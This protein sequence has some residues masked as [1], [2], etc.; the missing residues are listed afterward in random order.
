MIN[1]EKNTLKNYF[2]N[3]PDEY[4][5]KDENDAAACDNENV[6]QNFET[7]FFSSKSLP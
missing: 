5:Q 3:E 2:Q 7:K 6:F 1:L 4:L